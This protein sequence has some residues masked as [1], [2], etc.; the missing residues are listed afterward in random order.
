M[1]QW[2]GLSELNNLCPGEYTVTAVDQNN[3]P[4]GTSIELIEPP[5]GITF[6]AEAVEHAGGFEIT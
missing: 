1:T 6:S 3:C 5:T 2:E 4:E